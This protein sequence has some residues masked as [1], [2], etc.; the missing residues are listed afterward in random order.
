LDNDLLTTKPFLCAATGT[1]L[2]EVQHGQLFQHYVRLTL[3]LLMFGT[4][5]VTDIPVISS[6]YLKRLCA[7]P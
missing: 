6:A 4:F 7:T 3:K 2:L 5:V 1:A